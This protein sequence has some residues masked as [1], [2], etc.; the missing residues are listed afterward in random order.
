MEWCHSR[1]SMAP[2]AVRGNVSTPQN[3]IRAG[4]ARLFFSQLYFFLSLGVGQRAEGGGRQSRVERQHL[5]TGNQAV[6]PKQRH[7]PGQTGRGQ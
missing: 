3:A 7:E 2:E 5:I 1:R 4:C 6:A